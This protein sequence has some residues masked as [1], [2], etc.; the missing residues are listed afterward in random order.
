MV[1]VLGNESMSKSYSEM[2]VR[3]AFEDAS[4]LEAH[5]NSSNGASIVC[6]FS[7]RG[8]C[9]CSYSPRTL[10]RGGGR[11]GW[12]QKLILHNLSAKFIENF[13]YSTYCTPSSY[14]QS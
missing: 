9:E 5:L 14:T 13:W 8:L 2:H 6:Y 12:S 1:R 4:P 11:R 3:E 7:P 10:T